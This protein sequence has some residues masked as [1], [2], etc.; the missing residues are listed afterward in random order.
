MKSE[1]HV[2]KTEDCMTPNTKPHWEMGFLVYL[3]LFFI[4]L[5]MHM[6]IFPPMGMRI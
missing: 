5:Y 6:P 1:E 3:K 2:P 4:K